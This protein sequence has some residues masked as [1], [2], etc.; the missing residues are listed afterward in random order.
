[1]NLAGPCRSLRCLV[2]LFALAVTVRAQELERQVAGGFQLTTASF[3]PNGTIPKKFTCDGQDVSPALQWSGAPHN[4]KA[5]ALIV[6][7]PD[8]PA[9]TWTH[10]L[11]WNIGSSALPEAVPGQ[12]LTP[13]GASQGINDFGKAGY[14][15]PCPPPGKP[16]RYFFKLFAL[17][18]ALELKAGSNRKELEAALQGHILHQ[19]QVMGRYGR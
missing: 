8:A 7:D 5:Y 18:A 3:P 19:T 14:N 13:D 4:T 17:D 11:I 16:H 1:M 6:E 2:F 10:W 15:G 9:G 12:P